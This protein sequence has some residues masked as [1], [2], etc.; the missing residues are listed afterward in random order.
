MCRFLVTATAIKIQHCSICTKTSLILSQQSH[1]PPPPPPPWPFLTLQTIVWSPSLWFS[2]FRNITY[3]IK[4]HMTFSN[5][6]FSVSIM[7]LRSIQISIFQLLLIS[8][9]YSML[10]VYCGTKLGFAHLCTVKPIYWH[11]VLPRQSVFIEGHQARSPGSWCWKGQ[12]SLMAFRE[13]LLKTGWGRVLHG[14]WS[15]RGH[16]LVSQHHRWLIVPTSLGSRCLWSEC[17]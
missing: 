10:W 11:W 16:H 17:S 6:L 8:E 2:H 3:E 4:H 7:P 9:E 5:G 12:K 14:A 1:P 13:K 15:A